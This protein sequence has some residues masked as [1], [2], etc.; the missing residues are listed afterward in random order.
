MAEN[1]EGGSPGR[2]ILDE[3]NVSDVGLHYLRHNVTIVPQDP[4]IFTGTIKSNIDPF[5]RYSD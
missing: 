5:D 4:T 2:I 3:E 1:E